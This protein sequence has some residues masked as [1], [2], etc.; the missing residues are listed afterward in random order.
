MLITALL[1]DDDE[2]IRAV[3]PAALEPRGIHIEV[4][5]DAEQARQC[6]AKKARGYDVLLLDVSMPGESGLEFLSQLRETG[7][8]TPVLMVTSDSALDS[9][10]RGLELGADDYVIKPF[11][12]DEL[13]AR[14]K[15]VVRR[16]QMLPIVL[17]QDL[18][19]DL[20]RRTVMRG[21]TRIE[22]S[23]REFDVFMALVEARGEP[24]SRQ[25]LLEQIW[26]VHFEP[27][28]AMVEVQIAR[29]RKKIDTETQSVIETVPG[30]GY[31]IPLD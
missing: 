11:E 18:T 10:V 29:L 27:G 31:R 6:I 5:S 4:A 15:A 13:A 21:E 30:S 2:M 26:D 14:V 9:R 1:I 25:Q 12:P 17:V 20:A 23:P 28:T 19:V 7:D 16:S 8:R 3:L 24:L 22:L